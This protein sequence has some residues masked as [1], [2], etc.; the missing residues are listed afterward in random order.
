MIKGKE[1]EDYEN[2]G[3]EEIADNPENSKEYELFEQV[4]ADTY[5]RYYRKTAEDLMKSRPTSAFLQ[6]KEKE[7]EAGIFPDLFDR[8]E[9]TKGATFAKY[10]DLSYSTPVQRIGRYMDFSA[11][12]KK[13]HL[14]DIISYLRAMNGKQL[15]PAEKRTTEEY[16]EECLFTGCLREEPKGTTVSD[17]LYDPSTKNMQELVEY[18]KKWPEAIRKE[19]EK[20]QRRYKYYIEKD[21]IRIEEIAMYNKKW[22]VAALEKLGDESLL[23]VSED[24]MRELYQQIIGS[25]VCSMKRAIMNYVLRCPLERKRLQITMLPRTILPSNEMLAYK[26]GYSTDRYPEW[27]RNKNEALQDIKLKLLTNNIVMSALQNWF[28]D[29]RGFHLL[30]FKGLS[31]IQG[32]TIGVNNFFDTE[33]EYRRKVKGVFQHIWHRGA[34]MILYQFK[35]LKR[36]DYH[37]GKFTLKRFVPLKPV[38]ILQEN[39]L[40]PYLDDILTKCEMD[41][42]LA[43][44][45][46][47][48]AIIDDTIDIVEKVELEDIRE[49]TAY[50]NY[51]KFLHGTINFDDDGYKSLTK[52]YRT[53][54]KYCA[55]N[56]V[57][58]Q[59]RKV[60]EQTLEL[61][62][63]YFQKFE[64]ASPIVLDTSPMNRV[65]KLRRDYSTFLLEERRTRRARELSKQNSIKTD[66]LEDLLNQV[67]SGKHITKPIWRIDMEVKNGK[68]D[69]KE[70]KEFIIMNMQKLIDKVAKTFN[71]F[72]RPEFAK[73]AYV[74]KKQLEYEDREQK[75]KERVYMQ[76]H[77][78]SGMQDDIMKLKSQRMYR[79]YCANI[80]VA[81]SDKDEKV[82]EQDKDLKLFSNPVIRKRA[83][84]G[85]FIMDPDAN[86][87][88]KYFFCKSHTEELISKFYDEA[89]QL[90]EIFKPFHEITSGEVIEEYKAFALK[91]DLSLEECEFHINEIET[92]YNVIQGIPKVF[93]MTM[94][95]VNCEQ[96]INSLKGTLNNCKQIVKEKMESVYYKQCAKINEKYENAE[97]I[98]GQDMNS[99]EEVQAIEGFKSSLILETVN[100][101]EDSYKAHKIL[102]KLLELNLIPSE[103]VI[104]ITKKLYCWP[105]KLRQ[106]LED[107]EEKHKAQRAEQ[108]QIL[109]EK[110]ERFE[111]RAG[112]YSLKISIVETFKEIKDYQK[113]METMTK[114]ERKITGLNEEREIIN[115][116]EKLMFDYE[117]PFEVFMKLK[118]SFTPY[119]E[120][121]KAIESFNQ[122][123]QLWLTST[124]SAL[125]PADMENEVKQNI[126]VLNKSDKTFDKKTHPAGKGVTEQLKREIEELQKVLPIVEIL[127]N[128]GLKQRHWEKIQTVLGAQFDWNKV[129]LKDII[130]KGV[131]AHK[132]EISDI[133]DLAGKEYTLEKSLGKMQDDWK[134]MEFVVISKPETGIKLLAGNKL[135][136]MQLMLDENIVTAQQIRANPFVKPIEEEANAWERKLTNLRIILEKWIKVQM[137]YLYLNPIFDSEDI[138]KRLPAEANKFQRIDQTWREI[139]DRV[140][141]DKLVM[142]VDN[143]PGLMERLENANKDLDS[144]TANL[145]TYLEDKR[146]RFPRFY[147]LANDDMYD[148]LGDTKNPHKIETYLKKIFE[149]IRSLVF[150]EDTEILGMRSPE[151]EEVQFLRKLVP[152]DYHGNVESMLIDIEQE[153]KEAIAK[154][155]EKATEDYG[156]TP[157]QIDWVMKNWPGQVVLCVSQ[158]FWCLRITDAISKQSISDLQKYLELCET[159]L[160]DIVKLVRGKLT[161]LQRITLSALIVLSVHANDVLESLVA[162]KVVSES[163]FEWLSQLRYYY[164]PVF[165]V[166]FYDFS[167]K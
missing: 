32:P 22:M 153:M 53:E 80:R 27:N 23:K 135:E 139:M 84:I 60:I 40:F 138:T 44:E 121:W 49:S 66:G 15:A 17:P 20:S 74:E 28:H 120:I 159:Q 104:Q 149:G 71:K 33:R 123:R 167:K 163:A 63:K 6:K 155:I 144:I 21:E 150:T 99:P 29:F 45:Y 36:S 156:I 105:N 81:E 146:K 112:K 25:Y 96:V 87:N 141:H 4:Q 69:L 97:K 158:L 30:Y 5:G 72:P 2:L 10:G 161:K 117:S 89:I 59:M 85:A 124:F 92:I 42:E 35:Y 88:A 111:G 48:S 94:F 93:F 77:N 58:I 46:G 41:K 83:N 136:E 18:Q 127:S 154:Q 9:R 38:E 115:R 68:T 12:L 140:D 24:Q 137:E 134:S 118:T 3:I 162:N 133:S 1:N 95:E 100:W 79:K 51:V 39:V 55:G 14:Q 65:R 67:C 86:L 101:K 145:N 57:C 114:L 157:K 164:D 75:K 152:A 82:L 103:D 78:D 91:E 61:I 8:S 160:K 107:V 64:T 148:I 31:P 131:D 16:L 98:L 165:K 126:R 142:N 54:L 110:R 7:E 26:G 56:L 47:P 122:K 129:T 62:L 11:N 43:D 119:I 90:L 73:I 52:E 147:F 34:L 76:L 116:H 37:T 106:I 13:N 128:P 166:F 132:E 102:Y 70:T 130:S 109:K 19:V 50:Q 151:D 108:E 113:V 143:I 125:S